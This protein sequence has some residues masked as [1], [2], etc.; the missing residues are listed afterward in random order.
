MAQDWTDDC[1]DAGHVAQEDM[2][3]I[4]KN[5]LCLKGLFSG[6]SAPSNPV[7]GLLWLDTTNHLLMMRN[8]ANNAWLTVYDL[9]NQYVLSCSRQ[10]IAGTG[11]TGGGVMSADRT[12]GISAGGVGATQLADGGVSQTKLATYTA[13]DLLLISGSTSQDM[14]T[15]NK[16]MYEIQLDRA[17]TLRIKFTVS[18]GGASGSSTG[19][20]Y[21][22]G[23]AV[24]TI[25]TVNAPG[26]MGINSTEYSQDI[27]GWAAGDLVQLYGY[28][29]ASIG[30]GVGGF[31]LYTGNWNML[32]D[33]VP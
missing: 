2:A 33:M 25:R 32:M 31:K 14:A 12:L 22:N 20:I 3:N 29:N 8:E 19:R 1:F 11:L 30:G 17:G 10:I 21:R 16:K 7:A 26:G 4:E 23:S 15:T 9:A 27:S 18:A 24:G 5:F 6:A 13:G 28:S